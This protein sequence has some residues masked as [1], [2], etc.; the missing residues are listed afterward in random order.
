MLAVSW[1]LPVGMI[2]VLFFLDGL[3]LRPHADFTFLQ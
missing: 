2:Q 3:A 1:L